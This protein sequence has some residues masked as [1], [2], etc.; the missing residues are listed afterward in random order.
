M[1]PIPKA[2]IL[3]GI[4]AGTLDILYA[5]IF[6]AFRVVSALRILQS[7]ASGLLGSASYTGGLLTASLG[8]V[9]HFSIAIAAAS[10]FYVASRRFGWLLQHAVIS[11]IVFG[12]CVYV[13]MNFIV[14][15]L[16]AFPHRPAFSPL[17]LVAG[18]LVHIFLVGIPIAICI[19]AG[20]ARAAN[21]Y[22]H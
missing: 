9:L 13:V 18:L 3:S 15:P 12:L 4:I 2:I 20:T 17:V 1:H 22:A 19:R 6:Y 5:I 14:V 11:G 8:L 7:I 16:S 10:I 21:L